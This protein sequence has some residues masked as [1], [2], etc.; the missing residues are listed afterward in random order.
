MSRIPL[1]IKPFPATDLQWVWTHKE[2]YRKFDIFEV[3][4]L[5]AI[6][7]G[8]PI[9]DIKLCAFLLFRLGMSEVR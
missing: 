1:T 2:A 9:R 3:N 8:K 5:S 6:A 4:S 7:F